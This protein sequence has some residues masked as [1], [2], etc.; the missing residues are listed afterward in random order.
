M[1][2]NASRP[3]HAQ[4]SRTVGQDRLRVG[5]VKAQLR[6]IRTLCPLYSGCGRTLHTVCDYGPGQPRHHTVSSSIQ[7]SHQPLFYICITLSGISSLLRFVNLVLFT[8]PDSPHPAHITS[9]QSPHSLSPYVT[10]STFY[11]RRKT[12]LREI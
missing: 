11:S 6:G 2:V 3:T 1:P 5:T 8:P 7:V 4:R 12:H 10:F 9:S